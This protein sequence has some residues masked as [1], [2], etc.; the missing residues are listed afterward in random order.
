MPQSSR[1]SDGQKNW[2]KII[3]HFCSSYGQC[4]NLL[5]ECFRST[6]GWVLEVKQLPENAD[7][8]FTGLHA[9]QSSYDAAQA[10]VAWL[11]MI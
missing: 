6:A 1:G 9:S 8:Y 2:R 11:P 5:S 4:Q 10:P 7:A 3:G